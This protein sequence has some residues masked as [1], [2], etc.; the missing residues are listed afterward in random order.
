MNIDMRTF[1]LQVT[2]LDSVPSILQQICVL[3]WMN[4]F[5]EIQ[6]TYM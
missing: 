4:N 6:V 3:H 2:E 1:M 5:S